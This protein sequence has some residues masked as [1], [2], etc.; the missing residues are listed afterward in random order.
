MRIAHAMLSVAAML[1]QE[2]DAREIVRRSVDA[3]DRNWKIARNYT[4]LERD[5]ERRLD[6]AG[7]VKSKKIE[8]HDVT[9]LEGSPYRRLVERD[10]RA[11]T[12]DEEKHERRKLEQ[13]IAERSKETPADRNRRIAEFE[14]RRER[15]RALMR[16]VAEAFDF[17]IAG[18]DQVDG[19]D[20]WVIEATP[21]KGYEPRGREAKI[22]PGVNGKLWIDRQ[23]LQWVKVEAEVIKTVSWGLFLLRLD[24]GGRVSLEQTRVNDEVWLPRRVI[25]AGS[26]RIGLI[27]KVRMQEEITYSKFRRFQADSRLVPAE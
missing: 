9:L 25:V 6:S 1:A 2:P 4:F 14:K 26:A 17:R 20:V 12:P 18:T 11:L 5:E 3:N 7:Q 10:D 24:P 8:T 27:K 13:S 22:F 16:E 15:D 21:S 19:R 23:T